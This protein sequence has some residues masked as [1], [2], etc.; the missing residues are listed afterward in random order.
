MLQL[1]LKLQKRENFS[2]ISEML[3][4]T[5]SQ[6]CHFTNQAQGD[7]RDW[8][9]MNFTKE[10]I[11]YICFV[12]NTKC[13]RFSMKLGIYINFYDQNTKCQDYCIN[14]IERQTWLQNQWSQVLKG[15][16]IVSTNELRCEF[17]NVEA[18]L[19]SMGAVVN[20]LRHLPYRIDYSRS[21]NWKCE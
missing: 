6:L 11:L 17:A 15:P 10:S 14:W 7:R 1:A 18:K 16:I 8:K 13:T 9:L 21:I 3:L 2:V 20:S 4:F 12:I 5:D 19:Q